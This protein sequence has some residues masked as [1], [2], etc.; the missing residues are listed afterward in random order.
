[1][2]ANVDEIIAETRDGGSGRREILLPFASTQYRLGPFGSVGSR[3]TKKD[4]AVG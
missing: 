1:M 2:F 4:L 3:R